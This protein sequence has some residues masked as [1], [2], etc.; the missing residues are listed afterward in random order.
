MTPNWERIVKK[1]LLSSAIGV[2]IVTTIGVQVDGDEV[3]AI[4]TPDERIY[5]VVKSCRGGV[6]AHAHELIDCSIE[7]KLIFTIKDAVYHSHLSD[8][9][10]YTIEYNSGDQTC[11]I[12]NTVEPDTTDSSLT[13]I[14]LHAHELKVLLYC[15]NRSVKTILYESK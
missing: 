10:M 8:T 14:S 4:K 5:A 9:D 13:G 2:G 12:T 6:F 7:D 1:L 3:Y 15:E 11:K